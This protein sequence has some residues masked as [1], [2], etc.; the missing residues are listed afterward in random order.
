MQDKLVKESQERQHNAHG[1]AKQVILNKPLTPLL[2]ESNKKKSKNSVKKHEKKTPKN[3]GG[4]LLDNLKQELKYSSYIKAVRVEPKHKFNQVEQAKRQRK[5][6]VLSKCII[7]EVINM[8]RGLAQSKKGNGS[9]AKSSNAPA[10]ACKNTRAGHAAGRVLTQSTTT[11]RK[12]GLCDDFAASG[13]HQVQGVRRSSDTRPP[14]SAM[15][16][17]GSNDDL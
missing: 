13:G 8:Q 5:L 6:N 12:Q 11:F 4:A 16:S 15:K 3:H 14:R 1:R 17:A 7:D 2:E 10:S 9:Q